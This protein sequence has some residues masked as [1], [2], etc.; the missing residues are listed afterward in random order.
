MLY[1][2][3][4]CPN[5]SLG[6]FL[7]F[8]DFRSIFR[9]SKQFLVFTGIVFALKI[10]SEILKNYPFLY[11]PSP[12]ARPSPSRPNHQA[13]KAH[14]PPWPGRAVAM[15][16]ATPWRARHARPHPAPYK[17]LAPWP[18]CA[19][20][21]PRHL[22]T[23]AQ[24][25]CPSCRKLGIELDRCSR[26]FVAS[27]Y[28]LGKRALPGDPRRRAASRELLPVPGGLLVCCRSLKPD[29]LNQAVRRRPRFRTFPFFPP[30]V[31]TS[32][33]SSWAPLPISCLTHAP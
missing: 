7:E 2:D 20:A 1:L 28:L 24:H 27:I 6:I 19:L 21:D 17:G 16:G 22:S 14:W 5:L 13:R 31:S 23:P 26:R 9:A 32:T 12:W 3:C 33:C 25:R 18:L 4:S 11:G 15:A 10:N 8:C 29:R 30:L